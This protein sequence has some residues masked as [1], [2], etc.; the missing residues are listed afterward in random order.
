MIFV[1][2]RFD[3]A[4]DSE[5][6]ADWKKLQMV[7]DKMALPE[8]AEDFDRF[9]RSAMFEAWQS[10]PE[11]QG[12]DEKLV[13]VEDY[14]SDCDSSPGQSYI[15]PDLPT[16]KKIFLEEQDRQAIERH[17][18]C[19]SKLRSWI[20]AVAPYVR[21]FLGLTMCAVLV[22]GFGA[23]LIGIHM[24]CSKAMDL[25]PHD[26]YLFL[27]QT[28]YFVPWILAIAA[29]ID[30]DKYRSLRLSHKD[31][32]WACSAVLTLLVILAIC[33]GLLLIGIYMLCSKAMEL[34]VAVSL[35]AAP[36]LNN[37]L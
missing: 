2:G 26:E 23:Q 21:S 35:Y 18:Y 30:L 9:Q 22:I 25:V 27:H 4:A 16:L 12:Q 17:G 31:I 3:D 15:L 11:L 36:S 8:G 34:V 1:L 13:S 20:H 28:I 37:E 24:L 7:K 32:I 10:D 33:V 6:S 29:L 19:R 5:Q 14:D